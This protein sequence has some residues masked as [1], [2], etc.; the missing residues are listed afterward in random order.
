MQLFTTAV[1]G[2]HK[3]ER[4]DPELGGSDYLRVCGSRWQN[5]VL[6]KEGLSS[7]GSVDKAY[8]W[9]EKFVKII[10]DTSSICA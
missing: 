9:S 6:G 10:G 3:A 1:D 4:H 5:A 8:D 7:L 2:V